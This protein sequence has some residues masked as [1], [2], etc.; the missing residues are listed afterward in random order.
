MNVLEEIGVKLLEAI[1]LL[2]CVGSVV[3]LL[4]SGVE[5]FREIAHPDPEM[6]PADDRQLQV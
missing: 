3:V 2:G 1:F 5:D 4:L 6:P